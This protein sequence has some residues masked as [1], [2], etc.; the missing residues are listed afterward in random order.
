MIT[1]DNFHQ[2]YTNIGFNNIVVENSLYDIF[3]FVMN[4]LYERSNKNPNVFANENIVLDYVLQEYM[5]QLLYKEEKDIEEKI[6][7]DTFLQQFIKIVSDKV[8]FN[9]LSPYRSVNLI[10]P[11]SPVISTMEMNLNFILNRLEELHKEYKE[12]DVII[13]MFSK[14]FLMFKSINYLLSNGFETEAFST[15]RTIHELE[16]V[17]ILLNKYPYINERYLRHIIYNT[18]FR[19]EFSDKEAQQATIDDLKFHM[20]SRGYKSKDMKKFIEYGWIYAIENI[21][22][23]YPQLKLNFRNGLE[24]VAGLDRY[25]KDYEMSSEVAHSSPLLIYSNKN[26][27]KGITIVRSYESFLRLEEIFFNYLK[28]HEKVDAQGYELMRTTYNQFIRRILMIENKLFVESVTQ[29]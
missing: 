3:C 20:K 17:I 4:S 25:S 21:E 2:I 28:T 1:K 7:D 29:K 11:H 5:Y 9:E 22:Q 10:S 27:F 23:D 6:K 19:D 26:F 16:C 13:N 15:W 24:L 8:Y 12:D 14:A 18:A